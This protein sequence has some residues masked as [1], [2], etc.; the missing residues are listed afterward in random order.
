MKKITK[1]P[2]D[3]DAH[4]LK[5]GP[6]FLSL[7]PEEKQSLVR[8]HRNMGHPSAERLM[9]LLRQ[10]GFRSECVDAVQDM[11]CSTCEMTSKPKSSRPAVIKEPM[12]FNDKIAIDCLKWTNKA[13]L[14]F[15]I[16]HIIDF[17][18]SF[19]VACV[20]PNRTSENAIQNI[21]TSWLQWAGAPNEMI[22]D[23]GT[24]FNSEDFTQFLQRYN[25]KGTT[26][27]IEGH[28]QNGRPE[29]HGAILESMLTKFDLESPIMSY[30]DLHQ[31]L[32]FIMQAKNACSLRRGFA[33]EAL[34]FG[35]H[36]RLPGSISSDSSL[37][38][39]CLADSE[40]AQ[41]LALRKQLELRETAR[42]AFWHA[43]NQASLR[44]AILRR[45]RPA[46]KSF[47]TG[48]WVMVWKSLPKPG[49]WLGPMRVVTHENESTIWLTMSGKMYRAAPENARDVSAVETQQIPKHET[50]FPVTQKG[51]TQCREL[52]PQESPP[53]VDV[54]GTRI[55]N[56]DNDGVQTSPE[57]N[58]GNENNPPPQQSPVEHGSPSLPS[59]QPDNEPEVSNVPSMA[60]AP[61][62]GR[63]VPVPPS[64][65]EDES[66]QCVGFHSQDCDVP[67]FV[68]TTETSN[69]KCLKWSLEILVT[70]HDID[71]WKRETDPSDM[72]FLATAAKR[73]RAEVRMSEL[74]P[75]ERRQFMDAKDSEI[76]NW[77]KTGTV[78]KILRSQI[79][80]EEV[81]RCRWVLTWK[82]V[83][84]SVDDPD[85]SKKAK[86]RLVVLGYMDP[87]LDKIPRDSPTLG[88]HSKMLIL[89]MIASHGWT[90]QSFD[91]KAAFLQ[92]SVAGRTIG[93]E[94]VPQSLQ[95]L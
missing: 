64:G 56:L 67:C 54:M 87:S 12:D 5:H 6:R 63:E 37:P 15:H 26:I 78:M 22:V 25:I 73:Q 81:L 61:V 24:E 84:P 65:S 8:I 70:S 20:A 27:V 45:S 49:M 43:D 41:G 2:I 77:L 55:I 38:A 95:R 39:H 85:P 93:L 72:V 80:P 18:T 7:T 52:L 57:G 23:S 62:S 16:M 3:L 69:Q 42:R 46:R 30:S 29:R 79:P 89:Q 92:G 34:V 13:G 21:T 14:G 60:E 47:A 83:E 35:K 32:W 44:R 91:V 31:A 1:D 71:N 58:Q 19:H 94:P 40:T 90:L 36:T 10:Q 28:W 82:P 75:D 88:R 11:R 9:H 48:E 53:G 68:S 51:I 76:N 33:P 86:A 74:T 4:H 59:E 50:P 17:G 66:L